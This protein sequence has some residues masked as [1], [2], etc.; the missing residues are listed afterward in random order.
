M[1][2]QSIR[3]NLELSLWI[4]LIVLCPGLI[5]I[6]FLSSAET[7]ALKIMATCII[8]LTVYGWYSLIRSLKKLLKEKS[9][10]E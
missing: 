10:D 6:I 1:S 9:K 5:G 3:F 7:F 2:L 4:Y 8:I